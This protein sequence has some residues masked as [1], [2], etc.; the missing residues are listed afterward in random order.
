MK[1]TTST[2]DSCMKMSSSTS[3]GRSSTEGMAA[4][5]RCCRRRPAWMVNLCYPSPEFCGWFVWRWQSVTWWLQ[6]KSRFRYDY[7]MARRVVVSCSSTGSE[8]HW[9]Y[10]RDNNR[11]KTLLSFNDTKLCLKTTES[12]SGPADTVIVNAKLIHEKKQQKKRT[13]QL[14]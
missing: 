12:I 5:A 9:Q 11:V 7:L 13:I 1:Y 4:S 8:S 14:D 6:P 3:Y 10:S 2:G